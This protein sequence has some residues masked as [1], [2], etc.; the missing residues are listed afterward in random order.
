MNKTSIL[1]YSDKEYGYPIHICSDI[2]ILSDFTLYDKL[3]SSVII[4]YDVNIEKISS[5]GNTI[6]FL[7]DYFSNAGTKIHLY[8]LQ[9]G[10]HTKNITTIIE[11]V[12]WLLENKIQRDSI[13]VSLGGGVIGDMIG[14]LSSLY[15]RGVDLFHIPTNLL[16][17]CDSSIGGKT[18][19]NTNQH[20]NT[21][22]TYK[23]P[24]TTIMNLDF[25]NS[26]PKREFNAGFA[27]IIKISLL[28]DSEEYQKRFDEIVKC[29]NYSTSSDLFFILEKS[30]NDKLYFTSNDISEKNK[31][32]FLNF[33][34]TFGHAIETVQKFSNKEY[35]RHGEA[36]S[37]G[38]VCAI[39][40]S[41][42][43]FGTNNLP[44][45][46]SILKKFN[47]PVSLPDS[48]LKFSGCKTKSKLLETMVELSMKDKKGKGSQLRLILL[49]DIGDPFIYKT[50]KK[51]PLLNAFNSIL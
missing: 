47:L 31:R 28:K 19:I 25:L 24:V 34:H 6:N 20:V 50:D 32:L 8:P 22:G 51:E 9:S 36:V 39:S 48:F 37:L 12:D 13:F 11:I 44:Y 29:T 33:G 1:A 10:K 5:F 49:K 40:L 41:D 4:F 21:M 30:I 15:F 35:Y 46:K 7:N 38:M 45:I 2:K 42:H 27:E 26:L 14:F 43:I 18:A 17:M 23:H 3:Y 16:S